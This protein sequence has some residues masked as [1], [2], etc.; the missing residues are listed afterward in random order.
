MARQEPEEYAR[1]RSGVESGKIPVGSPRHIKIIDQDREIEC[2]SR[3]D[4]DIIRL[5]ILG[6]STASIAEN[7]GLSISRVDQII[8]EFFQ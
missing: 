1:I 4:R 3:R 2:L 6:W 5:S 8:R 7:I